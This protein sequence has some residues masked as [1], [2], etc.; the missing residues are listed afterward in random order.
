MLQESTLSLQNGRYTLDINHD[1][2]LFENYQMFYVCLYEN[3]TGTDPTQ[4]IDA[5][6]NQ[7]TNIMLPALDGAVYSLSE[8]QNEVLA[9]IN[10]QKFA[11]AQ[12]NFTSNGV[13]R[14]ELN[15][16]L[17]DA[18]FAPV[19]DVTIVPDNTASDWPGSHYFKFVA[20]KPLTLNATYYLRIGALP[21]KKLT[22]VSVLGAGDSAKNAW[23]NL[24]DSRFSFYI[25]TPGEIVVPAQWSVKLT[26]QQPVGQAATITY[27]V[28]AGNVT[29]IGTNSSQVHFTTDFLDSGVYGVEYYHNE[30]PLTQSDDPASEYEFRQLSPKYISVPPVSSNLR[31][32]N[33]FF[34]YDWGTAI[35][36]FDVSGT[37]PSGAASPALT[38]KFYP[39]T[40]NSLDIANVGSVPIPSANVNASGEFVAGIQASTLKGYGITPNFY[41]VVIQSTDGAPYYSTYVTV[42]D[43]WINAVSNTVTLSGTVKLRD[44]ASPPLTV[45]LWQGTTKTSETTTAGGT[46]SFSG[47]TKGAAYT[48]KIPAPSG[49]SWEAY[50]S[51]NYTLAANQSVNITLVSAEPSFAVSGVVTEAAAPV[52]GVTVRAYAKN[53]NAVSTTQAASAVTNASG[54]YTLSLIAGTYVLKVLA[55]GDY[56]EYVS[57]DIIVTD[58][59]VTGQDIA[60]ALKPFIEGV[61]TLGAENKSGV[62][63]YL[64]KGSN[65]VKSTTTDSNGKFIFKSVDESTAYTLRVSGSDSYASDDIQVTT[66]ASGKTEANI[67]LTALVTVS[68]TVKLGD[69][70]VSGVYV[71][72]YADTSYI[73]SARTDSDGKYIISRVKADA[74]QYKLKVSATREYTAYESGET[75]TLTEAATKDITLSPIPKYTSAFTVTTVADGASFA[76]YVYG[77]NVSTTEVIKTEGTYAI[78]LPAGTSYKYYYYYESVYGSG[79]FD[80]TSDGAAV[81]I[82]LP[83]WYTLSGVITDENN[84][85]VS[86]ATVNVSGAY[87]GSAYTDE[88]GAYSFNFKAIESSTVAITARHG[89]AGQGSSSGITLA[90]ADVSNANIKLS[91]NSVVIT[92]KTS[93]GAAIPGAYVSISS[94]GGYTDSDGKLTL[95]N[96][97]SGSY[98]YYAYKYGYLTTY[99]TEAVTIG[100]TGATNVDIVMAADPSLEHTLSLRATNSEIAPGGYVDIRPELTY[101]GG[102]TP[103]ANGKITLTLPTGVTAVG[104]NPY[105]D[106]GYEVTFDADK[107]VKLPTVRVTV[108]NTVGNLAYLGIQ[109]TYTATDV[110]KYACSPLTVVNATLTAP[111]V[112]GA[113]DEFTVYGTAPS[114]SIV[115]IKSGDTVLA[116]AAV[117]NRYYTAKIKISEVGDYILQAVAVDEAQSFASPPSPLTV[118][119]DLPPTIANVNFTSGPRSTP[120]D[121]AQ[122]GVKTFGTW[123]NV[124]DPYT[125]YY[126]II[127]SFTINRLGSYSVESVSFAGAITGENTDTLTNSNGTYTFKF[128][129]NAAWRG[130]GV[131][132]IIVTLSKV[133]G[134]DKEFFE[135]TIALVTISLDPSGY[136][137]DAVTKERISGAVV[138]LETKL[139]SD[140]WVKWEDPDGLEANPQ[141]TDEN[142]QYGWM[143]PS[144]DYRVLVTKTGYADAIANNADGTPAEDPTTGFPVP[145]ARTEV[146]IPMNYTGA[147]TAS[148]KWENDTLILNFTRP[149][150]VTATAA[151][152]TVKAGAAEL[153]GTWT[154]ASAEYSKIFTFTPETA[155]AAGDSITV[156]IEP[157]TLS[158][159]GVAIGVSALGGATVPKEPTNPP[160]GG[161]IDNNNNSTSSSTTDKS[162]D[163]DKKDDA[164]AGDSSE[165]WQ[166]PFTD[167]QDGDW[168]YADVEYAYKY[169]LM[170]GTDA[171]KFD[172]NVKVS[173]AMLVTVLYRLYGSPSVSAAP[174]FSDV[175]AGQWYSDAIAWA[176]ANGLV[177]GVGGG[178]FAPDDIITR[179]DMAVLFSRYAS[180]AGKTLPAVREPDAFADASEIADYAKQSV[181]DFN[182]AGLIGGVGG[183]RVTPR[184]EATRAEIAA[185][186]HRFIEAAKIEV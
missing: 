89:T 75:F 164:Q 144:G 167:V 29:T 20:A 64:Y 35:A 56:K 2:L 137:Y 78:A 93:G 118:T 88:T 109:A 123:V 26:K 87:Y 157:S 181:T 51:P 105:A 82:S 17:V 10:G 15:L 23:G 47:L 139:G 48:L 36:R 72:L 31:V 39:I 152:L 153:A 162:K 126:D 3:G 66:T 135:F 110:Y 172:P 166:N 63:V 116:T 45:E 5:H 50:S 101:T 151:N 58:A 90:S 158:Q 117:Q 175:R 100:E 73:R 160:G 49:S 34:S 129:K 84:A 41:Y 18:N 14:D 16:N 154:A 11:V 121:S 70:P 136:V 140:G 24:A 27:S 65:Y 163:D 54:G 146:N 28:A 98:S 113:G 6:F 128:P 115:A 32:S 81:T 156:T 94:R 53:G 114:G 68:G 134:E 180:F 25:Y 80:V 183:N 106:S 95:N 177:G 119:D 76:L 62:Y 184:G 107:T 99:S 92:V 1:V 170:T 104:N 145:P 69:A 52:S 30:T 133:E 155:P 161:W 40:S 182:A 46:F 7:L 38:A 91:V 171:D 127:G 165:P 79:T 150:P 103:A 19:A 124:Y 122:Y 148:A 142:G 55:T 138:T 83:T 168:F 44:N 71:Y 22:A 186:L 57:S 21:V 131:K 77:N 97:W 85:P 149:M 102:G 125:G 112:A 86:G 59:A 74:T 13:Y 185:L 120:A 176:A 143:V 169:G 4:S 173:R 147:P 60:L 159:D 61:A 96:A 9:D 141:T 67:T 178:R 111:N 12:Y 132:P 174:G 108:N 179:Q 8:S 130:T 33:A 37:V 42:T 43:R